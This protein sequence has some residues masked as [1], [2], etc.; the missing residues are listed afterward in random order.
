MFGIDDDDEEEW[1]EED[2]DEDEEEDTGEED[3]RPQ[4]Q[5]KLPLFGRPLCV[6]S[7]RFVSNGRRQQLLGALSEARG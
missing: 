5:R 7:G 3:A 4:T 2:I 6:A 1:D